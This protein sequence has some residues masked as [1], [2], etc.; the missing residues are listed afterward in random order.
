MSLNIPY[1]VWS[2]TALRFIVIR[3][4]ERGVQHE[5]AKVTLGL[6]LEPSGAALATPQHLLACAAFAV[7]ILQRPFKFCLEVYKDT[8]GRRASVAGQMLI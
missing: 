4:Q 3:P 7:F 1:G 8:H 5:E 2:C 6:T